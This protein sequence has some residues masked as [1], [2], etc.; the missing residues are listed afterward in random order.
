MAEKK[1]VAVVGGAGS[2]GRHYTRGYAAHPDCEIVALVDRAVDRARTFAEHYDIP[3]VYASVE[4]LLARDVPDVVSAVLPVAHIHDTVTACAEAGVKV[5]SC[6]KPIDYQL[7]RADETVRVCRE[8][9]AAFGCGTALYMSPYL[10]QTAAWIKAGNIGRLTAAALPGSLPTEVSGGGCH[11][12]ALARCMVGLEAEWVEGWTLPPEPRFT[13]PEAER[14]TE[15]D[16]P[17]YGRIGL[18]GGAVL[19]VLPPRPD[20]R[21]ACQLGVTGDDGQVWCTGDRPVL[22]RGTG[23]EATPVSADF[24]DEPTPEHWIDP[25]VDRLVRAVDTGELVCTGDDYRWALEIAIALTLSS[26]RNHERVR[27]PLQDRSVRLYP[28][29]YRLHGGD[30]VGFEGSGAPPSIE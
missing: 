15:I 24:F 23:A 14:D 3:T 25:V 20:L 18:H 27:L 1:R 2:W 10:P 29:P 22:I 7:S 5:I 4:E 9:G 16:C 30:V 17:A 8:R 28:H 19:E 6:E 11:I 12:L 26:H 21:I 13:A